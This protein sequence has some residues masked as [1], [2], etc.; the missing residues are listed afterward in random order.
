[1]IMSEGWNSKEYY[2]LVGECDDVGLRANGA[3]DSGED[4]NGRDTD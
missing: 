1:M 3:D 2:A 4:G